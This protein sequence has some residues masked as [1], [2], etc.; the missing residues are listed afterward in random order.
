MYQIQHQPLGQTI[1]LA[2]LTSFISLLAYPFVA[3]ISVFSTQADA[4]KPEPE[5]PECAAWAVEPAQGNAPLTVVG[6]GS[7]KDKDQQISYTLVEWGDGQTSDTLLNPTNVNHQYGNTGIF[8][9]QLVLVTVNGQQIRETICRQ[10]V[11]VGVEPTPTPTHTPTPTVTP[12]PTP[13]PTP[14]V[15]PSPTPSPTPTPEANYNYT[16]VKWVDK[17]CGNPE[18]ELSYR[19][20]VTN[21]SDQ[22]LSDIRVT[23]TPNDQTVYIQGSGSAKVGDGQTYPISDNWMADGVTFGQLNPAQKIEINWRMRIKSSVSPEHKIINTAYATAKE[24][25]TAK[26]ANVDSQICKTERIL[27]ASTQKLPETGS[28]INWITAIGG[29]TTT[30]AGVFIKKRTRSLPSNGN[31]DTIEKPSSN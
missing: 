19:I 28:Q 9:S 6:N 3:G 13:T 11:E 22:I 10:Q 30:A 25:P 7:F 27:A 20:T 16:I 18:E 5:T 8:L 15:T 26:E 1:S 2:V 23:D 17:E 24:L 4:C 29:L 21:T 31:D 12:T 14:T